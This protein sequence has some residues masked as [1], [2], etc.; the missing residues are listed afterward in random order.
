MQRPHKHFV[1]T[2][3]RKDRKQIDEGF[4]RLTPH[5]MNIADM[6]G[7]S[8]CP[9]QQRMRQATAVIITKLAPLCHPICIHIDTS[10]KG[11]WRTMEPDEK[12]IMA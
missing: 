8:H 4:T 6:K 12:N 5:H 3:R 2:D 11:R 1:T 9:W 10:N 7:A